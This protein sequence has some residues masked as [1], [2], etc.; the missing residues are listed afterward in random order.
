M[1]SC[2]DLLEPLKFLLT[3]LRFQSCDFAV[4]FATYLFRY[5][6]GDHDGFL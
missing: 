1:N 3:I 6:A 4:C 5:G 2:K